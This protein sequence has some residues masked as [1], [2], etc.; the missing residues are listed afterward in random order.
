MLESNRW[1]RYLVLRLIRKIKIFSLQE[2]PRITR[3]MKLKHFKIDL[4]LVMEMALRR[5]FL[6]EL[7]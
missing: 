6:K 4:A 5:D 1:F 3:R 2:K 7:P